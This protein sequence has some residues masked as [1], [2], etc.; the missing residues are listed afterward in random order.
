MVKPPHNAFAIFNY[1]VNV[2]SPKFLGNVW[3]R[4]ATYRAGQINFDLGPQPM[5]KK[6]LFTSQ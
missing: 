5:A 3:T 6:I 2:F 1:K 4:L